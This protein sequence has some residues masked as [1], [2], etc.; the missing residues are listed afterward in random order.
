MLAH[1]PT[2]SNQN[3]GSYVTSGLLNELAGTEQVLK[4]QGWVTVGT[5]GTWRDKQPRHG[6]SP[7]LAGKKT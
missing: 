5:P 7:R 6:F 4:G 1:P 2:S 3:G